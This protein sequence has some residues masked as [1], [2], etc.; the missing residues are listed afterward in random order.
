MAFVFPQ[1][2]PILDSSVLP[3]GGRAAFLDTLGRSL[4]D[5]GV[6]LIEYR[7]KTASDAEILADA[8][9]L[10]AVLPAGQVR[11]ILDDR[12]HLVGEAGFDGVHVDAGDMTPAEARALLGAEAIIGTFG[13]SQAILPGVLAEPA[14][15]FSIGPVGL[16]TTKQ[17][18]NP[19]IGVEGVRS[20]RAQAGPEP[21]LSAAG[22][23]TLDLAPQILAAGANMLAVSAAIF[24]AAD[25]AA[26]FR[27]WRQALA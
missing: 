14:S 8:A 5:A 15:Y 9:V 1:L 2:Y 24:R 6:T 13:G 22:G 7:N 4:A 10:R 12:A 19:P 23:V 27:R 20:L 17:T 11:L 18:S 25:P 21:V 3:A 16:T 26:E